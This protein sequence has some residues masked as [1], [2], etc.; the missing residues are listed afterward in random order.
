MCAFKTCGGV[1]RGAD[2]GNAKHGKY[3]ASDHYHCTCCHS[4]VYAA[5]CWF[6][7]NISEYGYLFQVWSLS[8]VTTWIM[9]KLVFESVSDLSFL[10]LCC[11][12]FCFWFFFFLFV[13]D[14]KCQTWIKPILKLLR[15]MSSLLI[16]D[17]E[18]NFGWFQ[19]AKLHCT[20][21]PLQKCLL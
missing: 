6:F 8:V 2:W 3:L 10:S 7:L 15:A 9:V 19:S 21:L 1:C 13:L 16:H 4:P 17:Y 18:V 5:Y 11:W 12:V 20:R 14:L